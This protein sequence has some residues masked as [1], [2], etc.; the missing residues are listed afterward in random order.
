VLFLFIA[1]SFIAFFDVFRDLFMYLLSLLQS[2]SLD[3]QDFSSLKVY[4]HTQ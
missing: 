3:L 4:I 2:F 1:I